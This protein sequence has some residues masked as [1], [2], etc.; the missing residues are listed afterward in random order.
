MTEEQELTLKALKADIEEIHEAFFS[1]G[2][3]GPN[4]PALIYQLRDLVEIHKRKSWLRNTISRI[5]GFFVAI[6]TAA[7][8]AWDLV[9]EAV[10]I[11][12]GNGPT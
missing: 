4:D 1:P 9:V 10:R 12:M 8:L 11:L 7:A 2:P 6:V 5:L 3:L